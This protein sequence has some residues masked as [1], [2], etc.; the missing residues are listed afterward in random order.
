MIN[1]SVSVRVAVALKGLC[2]LS[3]QGLV[4]SLFC[5]FWS[6]G[7]NNLAAVYQEFW[8]GIACFLYTPHMPL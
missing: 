4:I 7:G 8:N 6:R 2:A 1:Q 3:F 5:P